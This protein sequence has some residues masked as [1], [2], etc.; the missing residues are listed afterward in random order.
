MLFNAQ[1]TDYHKPYAPTVAEDTYMANLPECQMLIRDTCGWGA[2]WAVISYEHWI[3]NSD[4]IIV[5]YNPASRS[6]F[7]EAQ[8]ILAVIK[9]HVPEGR[10]VYVLIYQRR[11]TV[12][13]IEVS[14]VQ[15]HALASDFDYD[16]LEE[17]DGVK[18]DEA[19]MRIARYLLSYR[20]GRSY[21][22]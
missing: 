6:S 14:S 17:T 18:L 3:R 19:M 7:V 13:E 1:N 22:S 10:R 5:V 11:G 4:A 20:G 9:R 12:G 8:K 15:G 21:I 2:D 16:F